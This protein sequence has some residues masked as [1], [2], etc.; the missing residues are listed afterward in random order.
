MKETRPPSNPVY[1]VGSGS[2]LPGAPIPFSEIENVLGE[3][4]QAPTKIQ[5][6]IKRTHGVMAE[7]LDIDYVHYGIDPATREFNEDNI[8]MA[9][10]AAK[11]ALDAAQL[12]PADIDL[13]CYGSAHQDQMPTASAQI[14]EA[15]G[16]DVCEELAIHANCTSAYK[17]LYLGH[18]LIKGGQNR[19]VLVLSANMASS[20]LR[21]EYY[22]QQLVDKES[23]FLRWFLCDGAGA[24]VLSDTPRSK[25][26]FALETSFIE[27]IGGNRKSLMFNHRPA[28]WLNPQEEYDK[29]LHHLRQRFRNE[30]S[31]ST[32]QEEGG[33]IFFKGFQR[34]MQKS[35]M[36]LDDIR[37][38]QINLPAKHIV[39]SIVDEFSTTGMNKSVFYSKLNQLGYCGP[40]MA[41]ICLDKIIREENFKAGDCVASFVTEVSKFMQAGYVIRYDNI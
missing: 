13:I 33:S 32:F 31:T 18:Q 12:A 15:L 37:I 29:G 21:A 25:G 5:K 24:L 38:F 22:N 11:K 7:L 26:C 27:S 35:E 14:Q 19:N 20:E 17:A 39:D 1:I 4:T 36:S 30:L 8:S 41:F 9:V 10:A 34:M 6:W 40:P 16:I 28:Y 2:Y 23:L 3:L